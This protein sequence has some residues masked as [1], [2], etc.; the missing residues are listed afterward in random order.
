MSIS[1]IRASI[2]TRFRDNWLG[3]SLDTNVRYT[4][5]PFTPP[6]NESWVSLDVFF[7]L[8]EN[9]SI[10]G[11]SISVRRNGT[12]AVRCYAPMDSGAGALAQLSDE[13]VSI[14][15]NAQFDQIQCLSADIQHVGQPNLQGLDPR[16]YV[17]MVTIP[18]YRYE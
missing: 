13:V 17:Y 4:N 1:S 8:S 5:V 2:E 3:T 12:I 18:F 14:F 11:D 6:L 10:N 7:A 16:W 9:R 15:E